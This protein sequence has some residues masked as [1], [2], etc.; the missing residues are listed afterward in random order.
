MV[1]QSDFTFRTFV[2][3]SLHGDERSIAYAY[4]P[5]LLCKEILHDADSYLTSHLHSDSSETNLIVQLASCN[6]DELRHAAR[7]VVRR[8]PNVVAVDLNLGCPQPVAKDLFFGAYLAQ[9]V[10]LTSRC[11]RSLVDAMALSSTPVTAKIRID[12]QPYRTEQLVDALVNSGISMLAVHGRTLEAG[13][14]NGAADLDAVAAIRS[15]VPEHIPVLSNGN[16]TSAQD[17]DAALLTTNADGK[18][19]ELFEHLIVIIIILG[20]MSAEP[21]LVDPMLFAKW[22]HRRRSRCTSAAHADDDAHEQCA[23]SGRRS[24]ARQCCE[25]Q[26]AIA[27]RYVALPLAPDA[28]HVTVR[29]HVLHMLGLR[30]RSAAVFRR[31]AP[32]VAAQHAINNA[33]ESKA[34]IV[35]AASVTTL[36]CAIDA[37]HDHYETDAVLDVL[38]SAQCD[39]VWERVPVRRKRAHHSN[40]SSE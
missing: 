20:V 39:C 28:D 24:R 25:T 3:D 5:M 4:S 12:V 8:H 14:R 26:V 17:I 32:F 31:M 2:C 40:V 23:A 9:N 34:A 30:N 10:E 35:N 21:L 27:R 6:P 15:M 16:V 11:V 13:A 37:L 29:D 22:Q 7:T 1:R 33:H 36:A 18:R 38:E 19:A